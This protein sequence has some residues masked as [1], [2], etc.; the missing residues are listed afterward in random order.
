MVPNTEI[1]SKLVYFMKK[2]YQE[3]WH[4]YGD[5][6]GDLFPIDKELHE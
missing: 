3:I 4:K 2:N 5:I 1:C 6:C